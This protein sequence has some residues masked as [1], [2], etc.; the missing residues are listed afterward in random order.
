MFLIKPE[1]FCSFKTHFPV[2]LYQK[3]FEAKT[4][5]PNLI[6]EHVLSPNTVSNIQ[7]LAF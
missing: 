4:Y 6:N 5:F 1:Y 2:I 7:F 3:Y